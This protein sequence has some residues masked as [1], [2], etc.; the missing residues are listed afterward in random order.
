MDNYVCEGFMTRRES[1]ISAFEMVFESDFHK[2][3]EPDAVYGNAVEIRGAKASE[4][5]KKLYFSYADNAKEIDSAI[6]GTSD[7]WKL[8]RMNGVTRALLRVACAEMLY[9]DTPPKAVVN[10]AVEIAKIYGDDKAPAFINGVLNALARS[11]G[12]LGGESA[13][14]AN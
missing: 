10:E 4:F 7:K 8:S 6:S 13:E 12:L 9:T 3:A 2:G 11:R 5:A 14:A 1:R